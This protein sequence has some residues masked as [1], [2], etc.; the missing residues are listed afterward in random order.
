MW[1]D[2]GSQK[3]DRFR[4]GVHSARM[5][6][7]QEAAG[8]RLPRQGAVEMKLESKVGVR[9]R[10]ALHFS[11]KRLGLVCGQNCERNLRKFRCVQTYRTVI[12]QVW[13][14]SQCRGSLFTWWHALILKPYVVSFHFMEEEINRLR[15]VHKLKRQSRNKTLAI[16]F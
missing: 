16:C 1:R 13:A 6:M 7:R 8:S 11:T 9:S 3:A 12:L 4:E 15:D 2:T 5:A 10:R 14:K